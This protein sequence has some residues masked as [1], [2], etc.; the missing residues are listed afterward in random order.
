MI[1]LADHRGAGLE[2]IQKVLEDAGRPTAL[3]QSLRETREV[4]EGSVPQLVVLDPGTAQSFLLRRPA[5]F[6][7]AQGRPWTPS[8]ADAE[9][10][11][12]IATIAEAF[13]WLATISLSPGSARV[14]VEGPELGIRLGVRGDVDESE[15]D[16][17]QHALAV[18]A[19]II[20]RVDSL[21][22]RLT[23]A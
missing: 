1:L 11:Q 10:G 5:L 2:R 14:H 21:A 19:L 23:A 17:F 8:W 16:R 3:T 20:D 13:P 7:F 15:L 4:L 22:L 12:A 9:V 18:D 6:A